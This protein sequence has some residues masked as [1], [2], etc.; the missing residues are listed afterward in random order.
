M[1]R[2]DA[3]DISQHGPNLLVAQSAAKRGHGADR[4]WRRDDL[5]ALFDDRKQPLVGTS[6]LGQFRR[7]AA[8]S[9]RH[10]AVAAAS[11]AGLQI[12]A[13]AACAAGVVDLAARADQRGVRGVGAADA[14]EVRLRTA[15]DHSDG[16]TDEHDHNGEADHK[17]SW[18]Q[19]G[20]PAGCR[21]PHHSLARYLGS[22]PRQSQGA[23][24]LFALI[25][26]RC[27]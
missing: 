5:P 17:L 2:P 6:A 25:Y 27:L 13:V 10:S 19:A 14:A 16:Y 9:A 12:C 4:A 7:A 24:H 3:L 8:R 23:T 20:S 15:P 21:T 26:G 1:L 22:G 18:L 11:W